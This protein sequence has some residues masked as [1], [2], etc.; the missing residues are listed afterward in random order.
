MA[1]ILPGGIRGG[2]P[3]REASSLWFEVAEVLE[4][5]HMHGFSINGLMLDLQKAFNSLPRVPVWEILVALGCPAN[6]A[7]GWSGFV[8]RQVRRFKV[9]SSVGN[10]IGSKCGFP[11][12]CGCSVFAM[13]LVDL[14]L[15]HWVAAIDRPTLTRAYID[16]WQFLFRHVHVAQ[17]LYEGVSEF[18]SLLDMKVDV[19]K[20]F[21]WASHGSARKSLRAGSLPVVRAARDLGA[22]IN[23]SCFSGNRT[24]Q[25]RVKSLGSTWKLLR[26]SLSPYR[27]K[28]ACLSML[29]WPR[30]LHGI[31]VV[32]LGAAH[33]EKL[34]SGALRGLRA[35]RIG[36]NPVLH[37]ATVGFRSDPE[38]WAV[39]QTL[40]DCRKFGVWISQHVGVCRPYGEVRN[41][42]SSVPRARLLRLGWTI[43]PVGFVHDDLGCFDT[44]T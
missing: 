30:A 26:V 15:H 29:A 37:L 1:V 25:D 44:L 35:D 38:A 3:G 6:F 18:V 43:S 12:G 33:F 14:L 36:A 27:L 20:S 31:S 5:A 39:L 23:Y 11:E 22:H 4:Y 34:R 8:A 32:H 13:A 28:A 21:F 2:V 9:R 7:R 17:R 42:P 24:I 10:A 16:D 40:R 41:G 19:A